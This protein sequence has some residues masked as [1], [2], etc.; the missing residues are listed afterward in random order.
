MW[1]LTPQC[2][3]RSMGSRCSE[4]SNSIAILRTLTVLTLRKNKGSA[5]GFT[6]ATE[7]GP[8]LLFE[9]CD[10]LVAAAMEKMLTQENAG[11]LNCKV[12]LNQVSKSVI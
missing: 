12:N 7:C 10:I 1:V 9:K 11:K 2:T 8:E 4:C 3:L 6:G 5:K